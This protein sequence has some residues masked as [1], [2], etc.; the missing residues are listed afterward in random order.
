MTVQ[1]SF[2]RAT[3]LERVLDLFEIHR[4]F[5]AMPLAKALCLLIS[6]D[7]TKEEDVPTLLKKVD[8][9]VKHQYKQTMCNVN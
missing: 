4:M 9:D 6:A 2:A 7:S 8:W 1:S 3:H 5:C